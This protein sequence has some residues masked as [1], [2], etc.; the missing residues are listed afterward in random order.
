M[1]SLWGITGDGWIALATLLSGGAVLAGILVGVMQVSAQLE[2]NDVR[3]YLFEQGVLAL[4]A[5]LDELL[6][7]TRLNYA[8]IARLLKHVESSG[9]DSLASLRASDIPRVLTDGRPRLNTQ[10]IAPTGDLIG[11]SEL[12]ELMT[13]A[14]AQLYALNAN[15]E[16][17][18]RHKIV[19]FYEAGLPVDGNIQAW[20]RDMSK[21]THD[22]YLL[23]DQFYLPISGFLSDAVRVAQQKRLR[24]FREIPHVRASDEMKEIARNLDNWSKK[25]KSEYEDWRRSR[26]ALP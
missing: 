20:V 4:K 13:R 21:L 8:L 22:E 10:A 3:R 5:G 23:A 15:L 18:I 14:F 6:E 7:L 1:G 9:S 17:D 24:R 25:T 19:N 16:F 11:S 2:A 12:G 26:G